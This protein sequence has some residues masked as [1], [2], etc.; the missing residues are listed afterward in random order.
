MEIQNHY[1][2]IQYIVHY[3]TFDV[4]III[5]SEKLQIKAESVKMPKGQYETVNG[6]KRDNKMVKRKKTK[7]TNKHPQQTTHEIK[8]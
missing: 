6:S 7:K 2:S 3:I 1:P 8:D 5:L 4:I